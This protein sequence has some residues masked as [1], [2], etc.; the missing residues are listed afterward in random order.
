MPGAFGRRPGWRRLHWC[1]WLSLAGTTL[2]ALGCSPDGPA[3]IA[4]PPESG[5]TLVAPAEGDTVRGMVALEARILHPGARQVLFVADGVAIDT[6]LAP[7]WRG[8]WQATAPAGVP[9]VSLAARLIDASG[10]TE[11][12]PAV[13]VW[14]VD[15]RPP[16]LRIRAPGRAIWIERREG[17]A[18]TATAWDPE[19]GDLPAERIHWSGVGLARPLQGAELPLR[20]LPTG[21][22]TVRAEATDEAGL[23][24]G[25]AIRVCPFSYVADDSPEGCIENL[26]AALRAGDAE[27]FLQ[28]CDDRF[29][30]VPCM[31]EAVPAGWPPVW[32]RTLF[33]A[34][35]HAW[36]NDPDVGWIEWSAGPDRI[37]R[38]TSGSATCAW[39]ECGAIRL[40]WSN[41]PGEPGA[42][43]PPGAMPRAAGSAGLLLA[44]DEEERWRLCAWR[45]RPG[46]GQ[47][48]LAA[49][50]AEYAGLAP[51]TAESAECR[52]GRPIPRPEPRETDRRRPV[53]RPG[54]R[55]RTGR[56]G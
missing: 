28:R 7:P 32:D 35:L 11:V 19:S 31:G 3:S 24:G 46:A 40:D 26:W 18:L 38:W 20:L 51:A 9:S 4:S 45:D 33:A 41:L 23:T 37:E 53:P 5:I 22:Q 42:T 10:A 44:C 8:R 49:L 39:V 16:S 13:S 30:F 27:S 36:M 17:A 56:D 50:L 55:P 25:S 54:E 15:D 6:L 1:A 2:V 12:S 48:S 52:R 21:E 14:V 43:E 47:P 34:G 29:G